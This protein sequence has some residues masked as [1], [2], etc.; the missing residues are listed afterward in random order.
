LAQEPPRPPFKAE[1]L[2]AHAAMAALSTDGIN[3]MVGTS[4]SEILDLK[5][6]VVISTVGEVI[7]K[8]RTNLR[9]GVAQH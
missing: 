2:R 9:T 7:N 8:A 1:K 4:H 6:E 3:Q 5:P